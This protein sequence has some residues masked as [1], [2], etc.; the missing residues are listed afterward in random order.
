MPLTTAIRP[1][2]VKTSSILR[3]S[4]LRMCYHELP[5]HKKPVPSIPMAPSFPDDVESSAFLSE[6]DA[7]KE[8]KSKWDETLAT[9]SEAAVSHIIVTIKM[10]FCL[11]YH[12]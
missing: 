6:S 9:I 10:D 11:N 5:Q 7:P 2:L 12:E 4:H 8:S 3:G 1:R